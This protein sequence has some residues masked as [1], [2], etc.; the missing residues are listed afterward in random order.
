MTQRPAASNAPPAPSRA[1]AAAL[2]TA[3]CALLL[4]LLGA[5]ALLALQLYFESRDRELLQ[6]HLQETRALLVRVDNAAALAA[7][8]AQ[9][10]AHFADE[11]GLAVRVQGAYDQPL[12]EQGALAG[13]PPELLAHPSAALPAPLRRWRQDGRAWRGSAAV[14][15]M[16]LDGAAPLVVAVALDIQP[17]VAFTGALRWA[18]IGYVLLATLVFGVLAYWTV[19]RR[20]TADEKTP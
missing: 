18:L 19:G 16:P 13:L 11:R 9:L 10:H 15:R 20:R 14:M 5:V 8:P 7:L 1:K 17:H 3:A 12:Y 4:A 6:S 2:L